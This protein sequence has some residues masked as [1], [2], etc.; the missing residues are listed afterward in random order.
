MVNRAC[1]LNQNGKRSRIV[2]QAEASRERVSRLRWA[3]GFALGA[4]AG[5]ALGLAVGPTG[6]ALLGFRFP[7]LR[8]SLA[9]RPAALAE[10]APAPRP[11]PAKAP[12]AAPPRGPS[13]AQAVLRPAPQPAPLAIPAGRTLSIAVFGDSMADGLWAAL[14][15]DLRKSGSVEVL[16][17]AQ[18]STGLTRYDYVNVQTQTRDQLTEHHVDIAVVMFGTNDGQGIVA[19]D[20]RVYPFGTAA[21]RQAYDARIDALIGLLRSQGAMVYWVGLPKMEK[22]EMD[23]RASLLNG[24][25]QAR[26]AALGVPFIPTTAQT[27]DEQGQYDAYL[28]VPGEAHRRLMRAPDGVHMT[29][30]GYSRLAL[31]V[32]ARIHDD[33]Q[34]AAAQTASIRAA[35]IRAAPI[36]A[37]PIQAGPIQTGPIQT[38]RGPA[39]QSPT[40]QNRAAQYPAAQYP[41]A[42]Y[43]LAQSPIA[44]IRPSFSPVGPVETAERP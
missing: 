8:L 10:A 36:Q 34:G 32:A 25:F 41:P 27:V 42:Q 2:G 28:S 15:H 1:F 43:P 24:I 40:A 18:N 14:Y 6:A 3:A 30:A 29:M 7:Y 39:A 23:R 38:G 5:L 21:W 20:G 37:G 33:L 4:A 11:V 13:A 12:A 9:D 19:D 35:P 26:M 17:F 22:A 31:P 44:L 16:R